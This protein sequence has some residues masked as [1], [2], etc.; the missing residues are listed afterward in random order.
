MSARSVR[1]DLAMT[2]DPDAAAIGQTLRALQ[3]AFR[4]RNA[5]LL[6]DVYVEDAHWTNAFGTTLSGRDAIVDYLRGLFAD[7]HFAAGQMI[8][9]PQ[10]SIR[11]VTD[12][13]VVVKIYTEIAGQ[14]TVDGH[15]LPVRRNH[16]LKVLARQ[17]DGRWLI[18]SEMYMDAREETTYAGP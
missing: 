16:S 1:D 5:D 9:P 8:N 12:D 7:T 3:V 4:T 18:V 10:V 13:V 2:D 17:D 15:E 11:P 6:N 14:Q